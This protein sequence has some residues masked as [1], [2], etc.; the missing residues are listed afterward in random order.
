MILDDEDSISAM[1]LKYTPLYSKRSP[2]KIPDSKRKYLYSED[3]WAEIIQTVEGAVVDI[4][5]RIR[6]GEIGA[7]PRV[8]KDKSPCEYCEFK[9]VC[10]KVEL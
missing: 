6:S 4:S 9:A 10:R 2:D 7:T 8:K 3:G 1:T 5:D